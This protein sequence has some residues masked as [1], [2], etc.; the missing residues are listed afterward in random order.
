MA[1]IFKN[2]IVKDVGLTPIDAI[3]V[4]AN[5]TVTVIGIAM[6]NIKDSPVLGSVL[7]KDDTSVTANY[8]KD[9]PIA[10]NASMRPI[11]A[12]EK[13]TLQE[14]YTLQ[15]KSSYPDSLDAIISYVEQV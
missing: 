4:P 15:V 14:N 5:R 2:K 13:L 1:V 11:A 3:T 8:I 7:I 6:T 12:G 9:A 10:P